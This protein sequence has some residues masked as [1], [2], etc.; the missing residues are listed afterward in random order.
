MP[1]TSASSSSSVTRFCASLASMCWILLTE[2]L[3]VPQLALDLAL[4]VEGLLALPLPAFVSGD[5]QLADLLAQRPIAAEARAAHIRG[6]Q[7]LH[8]GLDIERLTTLGDGAIRARLDHL[9]DL[10][11]AHLGG[12]GIRG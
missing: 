1:G 7:P 12:D 2:A 3:E 9:A 10:L 6:E 11:L 8:L 4:H 5:H